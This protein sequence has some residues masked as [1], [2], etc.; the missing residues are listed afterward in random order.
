[1]LALVQQAAQPPLRLSLALP[2]SSRATAVTEAALALPTP[3][4]MA[5]LPAPCASSA[6]SHLPRWP[7]AIAKGRVTSATNHTFRATN[8]SVWSIAFSFQRALV[9]MTC[10]HAGL[11]KPFWRPS[12][13]ST[14][15]VGRTGQPSP[16]R[17]RVCNVRPTTPGRL[18]CSRPVWLAQ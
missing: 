17:S 15:R 1:M 16:A 12:D 10:F 5:A 4:P 7:R 8:T 2:A 14:A 18:T 11:L 9:Y 3:P 13:N 6:A